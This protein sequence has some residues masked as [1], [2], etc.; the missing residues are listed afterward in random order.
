MRILW[1]PTFYWGRAKPEPE[2]SAKDVLSIKLAPNVSMEFVRIPAGEFL[3]GSDKQKDK[4]AEDRETHQHKVRLKK[5][6]I[7]KYPVTNKQFEVFVQAT[8]H[9]T[10]AEKAGQSDAYNLFSKIWGTVSGHNWQQSQRPGSSLRGLSEHPVVHVSWNDENAYC[11]WAGARLPTEAEWEKAARGTDGRTYPWGEGF[12][13]SKTNFFEYVGS[14]TTV[15][16]YESGKSPYGAYDMAGN[17]WEWVDGW[18][19]AYFGHTVRDS[20][21][22]KTLK[23]LRGGSR[24]YL[25]GNTRSA[26]R[27]RRDASSTNDD[28]GFRCVRLN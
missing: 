9:Q 26:K 27:M 13:K 5:Y 21:Y 16:Q 17:V 25:D 18:Y 20:Y 12:D 15:G 2:I 8:G 14:T 7:G 24:N 23:V 3:M 11:E 4:Q 6:W 1:N 19:A 28:V 10:E 22:G